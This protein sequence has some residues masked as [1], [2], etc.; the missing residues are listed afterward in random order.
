MAA[1]K[2]TNQYGATYP[3]LEGSILSLLVFDAHTLEGASFTGTLDVAA[4]GAAL[5]TLGALVGMQ[6]IGVAGTVTD[7]GTTLTVSL[8]STDDAGF[9]RG[10]AGSIPLIGGSVTEAAWM[11]QNTVCTRSGSA[12]EGPKT[13]EVTLH[14]TLR[15]GRASVVIACQ[16]PMNGGFFSLTGDFEGVGIS[17]SDLDFLMGSLASGNAWFPTEQLGPYTKGSPAFGLLSMTLTGY[18]GLTPSFSVSISSVTVMVGISALPLMPT[19]LYMDPLGVW[20]TVTDP[21]GAAAAHWGLEGAVKLCNYADP[22]PAGLAAPDFEFDFAMSFP[23]PADPAFGVSGVLQN[24]SSKSVNVMLQ[25][26]LG[27]ETR[28]GLAEELT[29]TAFEFDT[30]ADVTTGTISDFSTSIAMSGRF[31]L[32]EQLT[33]ESFSVAV[34]YTG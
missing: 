17:L 29:V 18:I 8:R 19:A 21:T 3:A 32:F 20:V 34:I 1:W 5:T 4:S 30:S 16:V 23:T 6:T 26:L 10:V 11:T 22:G 28:I 27:P 15:V 14:V 7:D 33:L 9:T 25:D 12:D 13:D 24:P 31:G 2:F